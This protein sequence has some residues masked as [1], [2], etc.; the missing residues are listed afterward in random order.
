MEKRINNEVARLKGVVEFPKK[1]GFVFND[2]GL[3]LLGSIQTIIDR[4]EVD[5]G[6]Q[7]TGKQDRHMNTV[8]RANVAE[9]LKEQLG[10]IR[11]TAQSLDPVAFPGVGAQFGLVNS[12]SRQALRDVALAYL[13]HLKV[14]TT[15]A[16]L[17]AREHPATVVEDLTALVEEYDAAQSGQYAG[18]IGQVQGTQS[19][20]VLMKQGQAAVK[21]LSAMVR[22]RLKQSDPALLA[23]W[24]RTARV[25]RADRGVVRGVDSGE[26]RVES[27][28]GGGGA[29]PAGGS[30]SGGAGTGGTTGPAPGVTP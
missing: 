21:E 9:L 30:G 16:A 4:A 1:T 24:K 20:P 25:R 23:V 8:R 26:T 11:E 17:V 29:A 13:D 6:K 2:R 14:A 5:A 7:A 15:K 28:A 12:D 3:A 22:K 10:A 19:L 27:P 18:L